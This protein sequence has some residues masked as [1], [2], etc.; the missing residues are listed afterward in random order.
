MGRAGGAVQLRASA[1]VSRLLHTLKGDKFSFRRRLSTALTVL[2][3]EGKDGNK[4]PD[5]RGA[6]G[7]KFS[8]QQPHH[9]TLCQKCMFPGPPPNPDPL[10][11]NFR[12]GPSSEC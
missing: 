11:T 8:G 7:Q 2:V 3:L 1:R 12:G 10:N 9:R 4:D 6:L 5:L